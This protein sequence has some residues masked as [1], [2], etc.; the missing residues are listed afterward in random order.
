VTRTIDFL[1]VKDIA[2]GASLAVILGGVLSLILKGGPAFGIDFRGGVHVVAKFSE[3][4]SPSNVTAILQ[5]AGISRPK[6]V[7]APENEMLIDS[8]V[9]EAGVGQKIVQALRANLPV[10]DI[11]ITE[12][13]ANVGRDLRRVGIISTILSLG[14][15]LIYI[16]FRFQWRYAVGAVV[17]LAHDVLITLGAFSVL[18]LEV[19]LPTL[20]AFLTVVGYSVNDTIVIFDRIRENQRLMRGVR[21]HE[22]MNVSITQTITRTLLTSLATLFVVVVIFIESGPGELRTFS[23]ALTFG[24][25]VGTYSS[26]YIAS[27]I[28]LLLQPRV[29]LAD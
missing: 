4:V 3:S 13:G 26:I 22:L 7:T 20:A 29:S 18:N 28:V 25:I 10:Q 16:S 27:P 19:N 5:D 21:L 12:V 17:A 23:L 11:S 15:M 1:G 6:V 14:L 24:I 8:V 9:E 2:I